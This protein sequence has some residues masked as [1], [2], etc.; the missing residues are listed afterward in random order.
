[1]SERLFT[2]RFLTLWLFAFLTF[3]SAFQ[4]LPAI[5]FRILELGGTTAAA[6][7]FLAVYTFAS[8]LAA[9][10]MGNLADHIGRK[11]MLVIASILFIGF[12]LAYGFVRW[13]PALLL[14]GVVHGTIWAALMSSSSALMSEII[15]PSRRTEGLGYW[16]LASTGA[17]AVA[18]MSGLLIYQH[19]SW[20]TLC[21]E[22][23]ALSVLMTLWSTRL[24]ASEITAGEGPGLRDAW[25][26]KVMKIAAALAVTSFGYGG[27]TSYSAI[28]AV[29][30]NIQPKSLYLTVFAVTVVVVRLFTSH[31]ADRVGTRTV[32]YPAFA[33]LPISFAT[34]AV[35]QERWHMVASAILFGLGLGAAFPAFMSFLIANTDP[36][37]R[38]RTFGSFV[39]AFDTGIGTGSFVIGVIGGRWGLGTAFAIAAALSCLAIPIFNL[40]TRGLDG[41][42]VAAQSDHAG[43]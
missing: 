27:I 43:T 3:F 25:D 36:R 39:G 9:P 41:T 12:S 37:R 17:V 10:L 11:R 35:A 15:P 23:A 4:L 19:F 42:T 13:L 21:L 38:A 20:T 30:R 2:P 29:Q 8:A 6:G 31:L 14:I 7:S 5:P 33:A 40:A 26:W 18:P 16:G 34:L 24:P 32:L 1:M 28:L 22:L